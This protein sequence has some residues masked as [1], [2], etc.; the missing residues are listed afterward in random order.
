MK[1]CAGAGAALVR[2]AGVVR[3]PARARVDVQRAVPDVGPVVEDHLGAVAV[4]RIDVQDRDPGRPGR[5]QRLGRDRGV[6]QVA[7]P[8]VGAAGG[9]VPGRPAQR[10]GHR[11]ARADQVRGG[12][13][14]VRRAPDRGP[15]ARADQRHRVVAVQPGPAV[16]GGRGPQRQPGQQARG[17]EHVG[18][19]PVPPVLRGQPGGFPVRPDRG[20]VIKQR[21]IMHPAQDGV[22]VLPGGGHR[23][24]R[25]GQRVAQDQRPGRDL[26]PGLPQ[27]EPYFTGGIVPQ[28]VLAP[29]HWHRQAHP[30]PPQAG[31]A[32]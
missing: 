11:G 22:V 17:G 23:R 12:L 27:A 18:H 5:P 19:H 30:H 26:G 9:V 7:G 10:V 15:A 29:H 25:R 1:P 8:A 6:V 20:Q 16:H 31:A 3:E 32:G 14:G 13:R 4:V 28:A 2:V 24:A 21:W